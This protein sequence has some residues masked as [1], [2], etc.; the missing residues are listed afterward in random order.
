[1]KVIQ[2]LLNK[3]KGKSQEPEGLSEEEVEQIMS[4][5]L[6]QFDSNE[7]RVSYRFTGKFMEFSIEN[8]HMIFK[9]AC[10]AM[11]TIN[12]SHYRLV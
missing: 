8:D 7:E 11:K 10:R 2:K 3:I 6:T 4:E 5:I 12:N 1:M 9:N